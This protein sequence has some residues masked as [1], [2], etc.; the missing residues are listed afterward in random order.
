VGNRF[1]EIYDFTNFHDF[2]NFYFHILGTRMTFI[3]LLW[4]L[5]Y[6]EM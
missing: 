1:M 4:I 3:F 2:V 5:N 6:V